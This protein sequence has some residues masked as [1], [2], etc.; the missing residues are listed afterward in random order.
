MVGEAGDHV[1][2]HEQPRA[3][4][5]DGRD[6]TGTRPAEERLRGDAPGKGIRHTVGCLES[7]RRRIADV[8]WPGLWGDWRVRLLDNWR[9]A[10][11]DI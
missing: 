4:D 6:P 3:A 7:R 1:L 8:G 11:L 9:V 10:K 2:R 5:L